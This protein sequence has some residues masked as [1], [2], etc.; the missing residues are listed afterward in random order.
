MAWSYS[1][2]P[3]SATCHIWCAG[4]VENLYSWSNTGA[5]VKL[6]APGVDIYGEQSQLSLDCLLLGVPIMLCPLS[7]RVT[8]CCTVQRWSAHHC[9]S[10][11]AM[12]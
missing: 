11:H 12:E 1:S 2:Q 5:C 8:P 10:L 7:Q 3:L 4:D 6:F 9:T